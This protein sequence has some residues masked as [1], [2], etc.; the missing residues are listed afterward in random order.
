VNA[1]TDRKIWVSDYRGPRENPRAI[2]E[3]IAFD[4]SSELIKRREP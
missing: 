3:R 1:E 2:A 4:I